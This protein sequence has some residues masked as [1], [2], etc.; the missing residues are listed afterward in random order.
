MCVHYCVQAK[1]VNVPANVSDLMGVTKMNQG[2]I[3]ITSIGK[4]DQADHRTQVVKNVSQG[5]SKSRHT[6]LRSQCKS[7]G[8]QNPQ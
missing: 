4:T 8:L 3:I 1:V 6:T 7:L 2:N 5:P